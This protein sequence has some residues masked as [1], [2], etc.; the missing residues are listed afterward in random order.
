MN[1]KEATWNL[2]QAARSGSV[3]QAQAALDAGADPNAKDDWR[4]TPLHMAAAYGRASVARLL[5]EKGADIN[6]ADAWGKTPLM[7]AAKNRYAEIVEMLEL[8]AKPQAGPD[9]RVEEQ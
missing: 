1:T 4:R 3:S 2:F 9:S 5:I 7:V 8:V 6:A